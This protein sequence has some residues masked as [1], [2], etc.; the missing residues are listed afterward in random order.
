MNFMKW[1]AVLILLTTTSMA[2]KH[3][4]VQEKEVSY[5]AYEGPARSIDQV[6]VVNVDTT[7][8][9]PLRVLTVDNRPIN[10]SWDGQAVREGCKTKYIKER[11]RQPWPLVVCEDAVNSIQ[12]PPGPHTFILTTLHTEGWEG[13]NCHGHCQF[14]PTI[15]VDAGKKYHVQATLHVLATSRT[16]GGGGLT[17]A[18]VGEWSIV[19]DEITPK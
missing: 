5:Q 3:K 13:H 18:T 16:F 9:Y 6:A 2:K 10:K 12:L 1:F 7:S 19:V 14:A 15:A 4:E 8:K 17:V 11:G